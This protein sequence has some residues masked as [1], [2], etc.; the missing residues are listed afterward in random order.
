MIMSIQIVFETHSITEDNEHGIA[1]GWLP[2]R[3]SDQG[4]LLARELGARRRHDG[5]HAIFTSDLRRAIETAE[6]AFSDTS[7]PILHDWRLRECDYGAQNGMPRAEL[8]RTRRQ[9]LDAPYP[10]GESW[11]LAVQRVGRFLDD[12]HL[13]WDASRVLVIGHIATRWAF[14]H[15]L[16]RHPLEDLAEAEFN[17][18]PGWEYRLP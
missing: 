6:I 10:A 2:G 3:L 17:W 15:Y 5:L 1:T 18:Q 8:H 12:L 9:H 14:E 4:R 13:R 16:N 7:L 11:R